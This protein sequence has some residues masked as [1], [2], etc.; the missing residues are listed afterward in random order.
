M[1]PSF[2]GWAQLNLRLWDLITLIRAMTIEVSRAV[3][4][5]LLNRESHASLVEIFRHLLALPR[6]PTLAWSARRLWGPLERTFR[7]AK[8]RAATISQAWPCFGCGGQQD[9]QFTGRCAQCWRAHAYS[10]TRDVFGEISN[11]ARAAAKAAKVQNDQFDA[12]TDRY[13]RVAIQLLTDEDGAWLRNPECN[14]CGS[15]VRTSTTRAKAAG[16]DTELVTDE[17]FLFSL[18]RVVPHQQGYELNNVVIACGPCQLAK[19]WLPAASFLRVLHELAQ[20]NDFFDANTRLLAAPAAAVPPTPE[21]RQMIDEWSARRVKNLRRRLSA[22]HEKYKTG[23]HPRMKPPAELEITAGELCRLVKS[24]WA[25]NGKFMDPSGLKLPL[26]LADVDRINS[27]G[28]YSFDNCRLMYAAFNTLKGEDSDDGRV[29]QY[30]EQLRSQASF[31]KDKV[32]SLGT[33][34][35]H[36]LAG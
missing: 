16:S 11:K 5:P 27:N 1:G 26:L 34:E 28:P 2:L 15:R 8:A 4:W 22:K 25:G 12:F 19:H 17:L 7:S 36:L 31:I 18:D 24:R 14:W 20:G 35:T 32:A 9:N 23:E 30:L 29:N 21:E 13:T 33:D 3:S 10:Y 6:Q